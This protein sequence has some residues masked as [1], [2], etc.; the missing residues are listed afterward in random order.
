MLRDKYMSYNEL[1]KNDKYA[2]LDKRI[3]FEQWFNAY[4]LYNRP[5][6]LRSHVLHVA[7]SILLRKYG[8]SADNVVAVMNLKMQTLGI[9]NVF[10]RLVIQSK[11]DIDNLK[12]MQIS[13]N[14]DEVDEYKKTLETAIKLRSSLKFSVGRS[15]S[16]DELIRL[17]HGIYKY[18]KIRYPYRTISNC[19]LYGFFLVRTTVWI[20][21]KMYFMHTTLT[22]I[23]GE[24]MARIIHEAREWTPEKFTFDDLIAYMRMH[25]ITL[26][27]EDTSILRKLYLLE[28]NRWN[29]ETV[30]KL[31]IKTTSDK[32]ML[33]Y[34][35][36]C[37]EIKVV[38]K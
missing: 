9:H 20:K 30:E 36:S 33:C 26:G 25:A 34:L 37:M 12:M 10:D 6:A 38:Q 21:N 23:S 16:D 11:S 13:F 27:N 14:N 2:I 15:T 18:S 24:R 35:L 3:S 17:F 19:V 31:N 5:G 28:L 8:E 22:T 7:F 4:V 29:D 32:E 1:I